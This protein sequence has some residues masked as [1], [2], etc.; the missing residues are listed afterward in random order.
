MSTLAM[1]S[2][3]LTDDSRLWDATS[4][5]LGRAASS[6]YGIRLDDLAWPVRG[7]LEDHYRQ[8]KLKV[9][10]LLVGGRN[11]TEK[12]SEHLVWV[13]N[14]LNATDEDRRDTLDG[15]WNY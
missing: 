1:A 2:K 13:R 5:E 8:L 11:A 10:D 9:V 14:T 12:L 6:A 15:L 7:T 4:G 3:A